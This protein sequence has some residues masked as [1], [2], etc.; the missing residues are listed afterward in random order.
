GKM[1]DGRKAHN[2]LL[3]AIMKSYR[4]LNRLAR[5][6]FLSVASSRQDIGVRTRKLSAACDAQPGKVT[7]VSPQ[8][9]PD[10]AAPHLSFL[11]VPP[12]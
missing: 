3:D 10:R 5:L 2:A 8:I 1:P 9:S 6:N 12:A 11:L 4:H 7:L